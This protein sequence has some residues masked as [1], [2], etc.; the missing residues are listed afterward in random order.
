MLTILSKELKS[1]FFSATAYIFMGIFLFVSGIVFAVAN[2]L[3]RSPYFNQV[4]SG[5]VL[6]VFLV[7]T[8]VLTMRTLAEETKT[9][10][11]Q[12]LFTSPQSIASIVIGKYLAAVALFGITLLSTVL[13]PLILSIFGKMPVSE[14]VSTYLGFFLMGTC[15]VAIGVFI[16]SLTDNQV[17]AAIGTFGALLTLYII[18]AIQNALPNTMVSGI[19]FAAILILIICFIVYSSVKNII[20]TAGVFL[21]GALTVLALYIKN[22]I[23][24]EGFIGK[25]FSWFSVMKRYDTFNTGIINVSSIIY[26]ISFSFIFVFLTIRMIDKRRWS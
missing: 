23:M 8:P 3:S 6:F 13:F 12:L 26:Y 10:T 19:I 25:F 20:V 15:F 24:F 7:L 17:V 14:I 5:W 4:L 22:K 11:D 18:D 21:V 2:A 1:Y 9:K 16:S